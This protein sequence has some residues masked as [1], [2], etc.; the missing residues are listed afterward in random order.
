MKRAP[1]LELNLASRP[2]RNRR[3]YFLIR[4]VLVVALAAA[5]VLSGYA[6]TTYRSRAARARAPIAES[7]RHRNDMQR[8]R[9]R[10]V[11]ETN[12]AKKDDAG[13][14]EAANSV[15][16]RKTFSWTGFLSLLEASLPDSSYLS[17]L[18]PGATDGRTVGLKVRLVSRSLNDVLALIDNLTARNFKS[19][20]IENQVLDSGGRLVLELSMTYERDI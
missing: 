20:K 3:L 11:S 12:K 13:G 8:E 1:R 19:I 9:A 16:F 14:I 10:L 17:S 15:I 2:V 7:L 18:A 5:C 4:N 6:L